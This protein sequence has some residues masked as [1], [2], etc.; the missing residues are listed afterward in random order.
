MV[1]WK[2][3]M[4]F[5]DVFC[6]G[7]TCLVLP[8]PRYPHHGFVPST[9]NRTR[10]KVNL[11]KADGDEDNHGFPSCFGRWQQG[12]ATRF[13]PLTPHRALRVPLLRVPSP[14]LLTAPIRAA[15]AWDQRHPPYCLPARRVGTGLWGSRRPRL[16]R[17]S[18]SSRGADSRRAPHPL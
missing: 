11:N 6:T 12:T 15:Q 1:S 18:A 16:P 13:G 2:L 14:R 3:S 5:T 9:R 10:L 7:L 17:S 8:L 4:A